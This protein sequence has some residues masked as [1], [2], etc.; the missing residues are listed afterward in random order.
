MEGGRQR[1]G[2]GPRGGINEAIDLSIQHTSAVLSLS[3]LIY[4]HHQH[5]DGFLCCSFSEFER[6]QY[7][8]MDQRGGGEKGGEKGKATQSRAELRDYTATI[9]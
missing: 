5:G 2:G 9:M 6:N 8:R 7:G 4:S 3:S 1:Q